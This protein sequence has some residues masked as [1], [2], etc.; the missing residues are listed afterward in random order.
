MQISTNTTGMEAGLTVATDKDGRDHC[1]VVVKGTFVVE[2]DGTVALAEEQ[3]SLVYADEHYGDPGTTSIRYECDFAPSK[4]R[5]DV[6]VNGHAVSPTGQPIREMEVM[7]QVDNVIQKRIRVFGDRRWSN[8]L[9]GFGASSPEPFLK[10]LLV[11]DR[12][13]GGSDQTHEKPKYQGAELRNPVGTGFHKN[14]AA[15]AIAG[16]PLLNLEDPNHLVRSWSDTPPPIGYGVVGRGW[17]PRIAHAGTYDDTWLEERYPFLP[18]DFDTQYF[19]SAPADQQLPYLKGGERVQCVHMTPDRIFAFTVPDVRVP[20]MFQFW[21]RDVQKESKLDTLLVEP[22]LRRFL[23]TYRVSVP[24]GR[25]LVALR[26]VLVGH[27]PVAQPQRVAE[28]RH[29]EGLGAFIDWKKEQG[30]L[31]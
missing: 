28:K 24:L 4:P 14:S 20:V 22:D 31:N 5:A 15:E 11:Y 23:L 21:D 29:I 8:S 2:Q 3:A 27:Q 16:T 25:K 10:M 18:N 7:L 30:T 17:Q 12:A 1:V 6:L 26:E 13:F 19:Q 9:V